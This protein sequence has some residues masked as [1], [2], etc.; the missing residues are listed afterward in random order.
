MYFP[1]FKRSLCLRS[2]STQPPIMEVSCTH[3]EITHLSH[4]HSTSEKCPTTKAV[5]IA[6]FSHLGSCT[7]LPG[8]HSACVFSPASVTLSPHNSLGSPLSFRAVRRPVTAGHPK[9]GRMCL[10]TPL[11]PP[12]R[13]GKRIPDEPPNCEKHTHW[14]KFNKWTRRQREQRSEAL[15][16]VWQ[17]WVS[18]GQAHLG[19]LAPIIYLLVHESLP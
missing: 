2:L 16:T 13:T 5:L 17:D 12:P 18:G 19:S 14:S 8:C 6:Q 15:I 11:G 3:P 4:T 9:P 7:R 1:S 10:P